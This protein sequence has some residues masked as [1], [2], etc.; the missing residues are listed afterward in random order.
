MTGYVTFSSGRGRCCTRSIIPPAGLAL[1]RGYNSLIAATSRLIVAMLRPKIHLMRST[2]A[3]SMRALVSCRKASMPALVSCRKASMPALVSCRNVSMS[4][5]MVAIG[6]GGEILFEQPCLLT[7]D[8]LGLALGHA[9]AHQ[10]MDS[11][12]CQG[13]MWAS[14]PWLRSSRFFHSVAVHFA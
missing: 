10:F 5:L 9:G 12:A 13:S 2:F 3:V 6:L 8:G 11:Y 14:V 1:D 4:A 7:H